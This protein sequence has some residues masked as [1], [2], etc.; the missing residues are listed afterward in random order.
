VNHTDAAPTTR[1]VDRNGKTYTHNI[2][3]QKKA[4]NQKAKKPAA[5]FRAI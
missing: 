4:G 1:A 3:V 5:V 2:A